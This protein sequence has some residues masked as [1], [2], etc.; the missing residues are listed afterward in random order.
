MFDIIILLLQRLKFFHKNLFCL[1]VSRTHDKS[2]VSFFEEYF[3]FIHLIFNFA[4]IALP[5]YG[6]FLFVKRSLRHVLYARGIFLHS[7]KK[8]VL[9]WLKKYFMLNIVK[10]IVL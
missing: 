5:C 1:K 10:T 2:C 6:C 8:E 9:K 3:I 7:M 4:P